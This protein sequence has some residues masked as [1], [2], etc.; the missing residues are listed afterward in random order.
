MSKS[1]DC[2]TYEHTIREP[3][4]GETDQIEYNSKG[5]ILTWSLWTHWF[6]G[7][8]WFSQ[9]LNRIAALDPE[10]FREMQKQIDKLAILRRHEEKLSGKIVSMFTTSSDDNYSEGA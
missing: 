2:K 6:G 1:N 8:M 9:D 5:E 7:G 4:G 3:G 10:A